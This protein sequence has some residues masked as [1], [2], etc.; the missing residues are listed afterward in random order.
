MDSSSL[1]PATSAN[2]NDTAT[3]TTTIPPN[4][5]ATTMVNKEEKEN[6]QEEVS[7]TTT[8]AVTSPSAAVS[9]AISD[10]ISAVAEAAATQQTRFSFYD[11]QEVQLQMGPLE[12]TT[13]TSTSSPLSEVG[14][15]EIITYAPTDEQ[16]FSP[17]KTE[18]S[19]TSLSSARSLPLRPPREML[20]RKSK[21]V[22]ELELLL[23]LP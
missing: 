20:E 6:T 10:A 2:N 22:V 4:N 7:A 1:A 19:T 13:I 18:T 15:M 23:L 21:K 3:T 16:L 8:V 5:I 11:A 9:N 14:A 17:Q 12:E